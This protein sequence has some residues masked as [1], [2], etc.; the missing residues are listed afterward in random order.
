MICPKGTECGEITR[1]LGLLRR[2]RSSKVTEFAT[3]QKLICSLL[4]VIN[5]SL[6]IKDLVN[7]AKAKTYFLKAKDI[8]IFQGQLRQLPLRAKM[9]IAVTKTENAY[10]INTMQ[11]KRFVAVLVFNIQINV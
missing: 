7:E 9:C 3:K 2:S 5:T 6:V 1:Q 8:K 11:K 4:L 10:L